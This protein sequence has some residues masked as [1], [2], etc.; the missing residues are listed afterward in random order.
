MTIHI[1][2]YDEEKRKLHI[3]FNG[4]WTL[5][6]FQN[7]IL[8]VNDMIESQSHM[9]HVIADLSDCAPPSTAVLPAIGSAIRNFEADW[10][11]AVVLSKNNMLEHLVRTI[12]SMYPSLR[13]R[14]YV[15]ESLEIGKRIMTHFEKQRRVT[16]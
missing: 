12:T 4:L 10:G 15:V 7:M 8:Q 5:D 2:W 3:C 1:S 13:Q 14:V 9:V 6:D 16:A 11:V